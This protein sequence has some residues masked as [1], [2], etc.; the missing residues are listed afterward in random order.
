M[1]FTIAAESE[2]SGVES[3]PD[4]SDDR[5]SGVR[6]VHSRELDFERIYAQY[7][8][9]VSRWVRAFGAPDSEVD[10]LTQEVFLVVRRKLDQFDGRNLPAWLYRIAQRTVSDHRRR[11]WFRRL[12]RRSQRE[13]DS[14]ASDRSG[15]ADL[16]ERR[17]AERVV[18]QVLDRMSRVRRTAFALF[19]IEGYTCEEIAKLEQIPV[20]TVYTR[21]HHARKDFFRLLAELTG[22]PREG[23]L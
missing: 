12:F 3:C 4:Y 11:A 13:L 6:P 5:T 22:E 23:A 18:R 16:L 21:L 2:S 8:G 14:L 19:E 7:F 10:D 9:P 20:N 17:E 15:P 1:G